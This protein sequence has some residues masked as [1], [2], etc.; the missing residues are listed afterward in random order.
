MRKGKAR[1]VDLSEAA[2]I[3]KKANESGLVHLGLYMPA[4]ELF[5]LCSC[6]SCC[7]H[8]LQIVKQF[9]RK[10][11]MIH[12]EYIAAT[13]SENCIHCSVCVDRCVFGARVFQDGKVEY[14]PTECLGCGLCV[15]TCPA[16]AISMEVR[17]G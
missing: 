16:E 15:T 1:H 14:I 7:C 13:L 9:D 17:E 2:E 5:A 10:G 12:S 3:S 4:H 6:C 8:D 11:L